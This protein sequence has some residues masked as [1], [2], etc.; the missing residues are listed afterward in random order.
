MVLNKQ[1]D[2][3]YEID[4]VGIIKDYDKESLVIFYPTQE[5]TEIMNKR[6]WNP[7]HNYLSYVSINEVEEFERQ[8]KVATI[9]MPY[10]MVA[11][12]LTQILG[13]NIYSLK[14]NQCKKV[15]HNESARSI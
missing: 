10:E 13:E 2:I 15:H 7:N 1:E 12:I 9:D 6:Y 8:N 11:I 14:V 3:Y 4:T 5:P